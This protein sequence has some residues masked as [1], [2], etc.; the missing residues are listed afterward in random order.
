MPRLPGGGG[1]IKPSIM[2]GRRAPGREEG[3]V[4]GPRV[5]GPLGCITPRGKWG[6]SVTVLQDG[7]SVASE[8]MSVCVCWY[9]L[10]QDCRRACHGDLLIRDSDRW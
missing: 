3:G 5:S 2:P 9:V 8:C 4:W 10:R 6:A 1:D 7:H